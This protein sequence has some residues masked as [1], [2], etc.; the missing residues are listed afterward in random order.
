M[1]CGDNSVDIFITPRHTDMETWTN[2]FSENIQNRDVD[3][4]CSKIL[5]TLNEKNIHI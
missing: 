3:F 4:G 1:N 2:N 5:N